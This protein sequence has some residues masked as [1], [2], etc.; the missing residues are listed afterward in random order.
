MNCVH[1]RP[2]KVRGDSANQGKTMLVPCGKCIAC[3]INRRREWTQRL[4]HESYLADSAYFVTLTYNDDYLP[5]DPETGAAMVSKLDIQRFLKSLRK[6]YPGVK[7]R[8]F[9]GSEYGEQ[10]PT[11]R[12]HYH[13]IFYNLPA[14]ALLPLDGLPPGTPLTKR[15]NSNVSMINRKINEIWK[16][17]FV[18][19]GEINRERASYCAK[20]FVDKQDVP[21]GQAP[22]FNLMSR[23]PGI[24]AG[25]VEQIRDKVRAYNLHSCIA[26]N[27][28]YLPLPRYYDKKIWTDEERKERFSEEAFEEMQNKILESSSFKFEDESEAQIIRHHSFKNLHKQL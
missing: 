9:V 24:G 23:R 11:R 19:V 5:Y 21:P 18:T 16:K 8:Y 4:L 27:G 12:P 6:H 10:I 25:Y 20:Y 14:D 2:I 22:N 1:P 17:G 13:G 26:D 15:H 3:R 7:I 28:K